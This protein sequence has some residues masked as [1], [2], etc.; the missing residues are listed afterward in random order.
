MTGTFDPFSQRTGGIWR[1][2]MG[3]DRYTSVANAFFRDPALSAKAKGVFGLIS[4]HREGWALTVAQIVRDMRDGTA[5]I[6]SALSELEE[7]SYLYRE[8][9]RN[10]DGTLGEQLYI[11]SDDK[12]FVRDLAAQR[13]AFHAQT[14]EAKQNPSSEPGCDSPTLDE[15]TLA[16][17]TTKKT[18]YKK[19]NKKEPQTAPSARS[20]PDAGGSTSGSRRDEAAS[21]SAASG[22]ATAPK[23]S[24]TSQ[25]A[26]RMT[27]AEAKAVR[28]VEA[29]WPKELAELLPPYTLPVI[30]DA[31]LAALDARTAQQLTERIRHR[32]EAYG[33]AHDLLSAEG[34]GL[35]S[36]VGVAVALVRPSTDCPDP[37]CE[38][39]TNLSSGAP[40]RVCPERRADR[41]SRRGSGA[42]S[43]VGTS[44]HWECA[45]PTCR[46][47]GKGTP[48]EDG[49][50]PACRAE[51]EAATAQF[52]M[53]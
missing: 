28:A 49:L 20:A 38:D 12:S 36:A 13:A 7:Q 47:P 40:C 11:V 43:A 3:A 18:N 45:V 53:P 34:R 25:S 15:S 39:G 31:V 44:E 48:A 9:L 51:L 29:A 16:N 23:K 4:T 27:R 1:G 50:C 37:M 32:W 17:R 22:G 14:R 19:T 5:A 33:F 10:E 24:S 52:Q 21:G 42:Q 30:R 41:R 26:Q 46:R 35:K 2:P 8:R 6:R